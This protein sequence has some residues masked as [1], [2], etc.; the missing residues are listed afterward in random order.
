MDDP[1][2]GAADPKP[3]PALRAE[4]AALLGAVIDRVRAEPASTEEW[5][6]PAPAIARAADVL[7]VFFGNPVLA[8]DRV[9]NVCRLT[10][11]ASGGVT[12]SLVENDPQVVAWGWQVAARHYPELAASV[13]AECVAVT[14]KPCVWCEGRG[15][16]G[17]PGVATAERCP[18]CGGAG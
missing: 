14:G 10:W 13:P 3:R 12:D 4:D 17:P 16:G 6:S 9:G 11:T 5:P 18:L 8:L 2:R 1:D 15:H 7:L